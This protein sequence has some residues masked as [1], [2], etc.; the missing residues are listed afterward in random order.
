VSH[1]PFAPSATKR[2][3]ACRGSFGLSLQVPEPPETVYAEEG[4]R[5]HG[6]AAAY[7]NTPNDPVMSAGDWEAIKPYLCYAA[8]R[9]AVSDFACIE[10][11]LE[12]SPLLF[13]TPDLM[14]G[15]NDVD[16]PGGLLE[17]VDLKTGA[18]ILV[19]AEENEQLMTYAWM[20]LVAFRKVGRDFERVRLTIVQPPDEDR[21]VK[22]WDTTAERIFEHA[23]RCVQAIDEALAGGAELVPG[24]HCRF[25]KAKPTCP[26]LRGEVVEALGGGLPT[27]MTPLALAVWLDRA[28]RMEGF[29][30]AVREVGHALAS[31]GAVVPG[32]V[33]K[34]KRATRQWD[35]EDAVLE[36][37]RRRKIKIY[38]DKMLSPAMAEKAHANLPQELRDHIVAVSSGMNLVRGENPPEVLKPEATKMDKL[39]ANMALMKHR[40]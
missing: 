13:G 31:A 4:S 34:P 37:A 33:L 2:W 7:L 11:R 10:Q 20:A 24:D 22:S 39:M 19:N 8:D 25:C 14:M 38:Q 32:W 18:G 21:P 9:I 6:L 30:K 16:E 12:Y 15:F 5:L 27:T 17:I 23:E 35:D 26:K 29:I 1:A 3:L 40:R 36:I 28:E